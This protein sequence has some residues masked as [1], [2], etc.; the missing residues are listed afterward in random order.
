MLPLLPQ[1]KANHFAYGAILAAIGCLF[2][3]LAGAAL[4]V[5]FAVGKEVYDRL[6]GKGNPEF[7]DA[8]ATIAGG[9]IVIIPTVA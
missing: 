3:P 4:C 2:S 1:D 8:I 9:V 7:L 6:S 5:A